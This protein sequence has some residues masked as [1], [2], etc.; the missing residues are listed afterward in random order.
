MINFTEIEEDFKA[1]YNRSVSDDPYK[2]VPE[3]GYSFDELVEKTK[4]VYFD[5]SIS[6]DELWKILIV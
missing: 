2:N 1:S 3:N 4:I 6:V 5:A